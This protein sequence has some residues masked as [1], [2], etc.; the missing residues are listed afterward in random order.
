MALF[1]DVKNGVYDRCVTSFEEFTRNFEIM[2]TMKVKY[3]IS[4]TKKACQILSDIIFNA[5]ENKSQ[6]T[7]CVIYDLLGLFI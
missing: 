5:I 2:V 6:L 7:R 1:F 4:V 3:H